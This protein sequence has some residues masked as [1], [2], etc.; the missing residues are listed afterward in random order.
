M[1][2]LKEKEV[3]MM[4][5]GAVLILCLV[6]CQY[7]AIE[8]PIIGILGKPVEDDTSK[9]YFVAFYV[10]WIEQSGARV[11]PIPHDVHKK[12]ELLQLYLTSLNGVLFTGGDLGLAL[13]SDYVKSATHFYNHSFTMAAKGETFP[14]WGTCMGFQLLHILVAQTTDVLTDGYDSWDVS[15]PLTLTPQ[16]HQSRFFSGFPP[17]VVKDLS[18]QNITLNFHKSG[19]LPKA[20]HTYP[21]L[22]TTFD[23]LSTNH[24][25]KGT[26]F[27]STIEAKHAP[28]YGTQWHPE[29]SQ[30]E[31]NDYDHGISYT[32]SARN[33]MY[34]ASS[35]F[36]N[37]CRKSNQAFDSFDTLDKYIIFNYSP[38]YNGFSTQTYQF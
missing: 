18:S 28:I 34:A 36:A 17:E 1:D 14:I 11:V 33:A 12:P 10:K 4:R 20:Y 30:F 31:F 8:N 2:R 24:D 21:E 6:M 27:I 22:A 35:F 25:L 32:Q 9:S 29:R 38:T 23:I 3:K 15:F 37:Q 16:A 13:D 5:K 26:P 19:I 7:L